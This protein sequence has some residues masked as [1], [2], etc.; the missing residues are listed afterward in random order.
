MVIEDIDIA[1]LFPRPFKVLIQVFKDEF[2]AGLRVLISRLDLVTKQD[3][4]IQKR[5][6]EEAYDEIK[7]LKEGS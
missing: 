2:H 6:L 7:R 1:A 3:Y 5:L 4:I